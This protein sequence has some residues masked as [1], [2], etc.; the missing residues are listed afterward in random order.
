MKQ[1]AVLRAGAALAAAAAVLAACS[2][3]IPVR[4]SGSLEQ[5][6]ATFG[7]DPAKPEKACLGGI[8]VHER[9]NAMMR[10]VWSIEARGR[11]CRGLRQVVYGQTPEGFETTV[12][13]TPLQPGVRYAVVG[14][15]LTGGPLSRVPWR[16]G[17]EEVLF[18]H[19]RWRPVTAQERSPLVDEVGEARH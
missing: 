13:P 18:E 11:N 19:G 1:V 15:G 12:E 10:P 17:G 4:I 6:I 5:P 3:M 8:A 2:A 7:L 14:Y 16:G 9:S